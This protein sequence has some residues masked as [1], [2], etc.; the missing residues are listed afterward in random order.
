M[1][2][3]FVMREFRGHDLARAAAATIFETLPGRWELRVMLENPRA[4]AFWRAAIKSG[5]YSSVVE[6]RK[7]VEV[8]SRDMIVF[9]FDTSSRLAS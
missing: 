6:T 5:N 2:E 1:H 4:R 9:Q 3:F 7:Y 8:D